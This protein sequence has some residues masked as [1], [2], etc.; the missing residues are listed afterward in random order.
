MI[1]Q[2]NFNW[3][4][5]TLGCHELDLP[6]VCELAQKH[7][8]HQLEIRGLGDSLNLPEYLE[9]KFPDGPNSVQQILDQHHQAVIALNS[10]FNLLGADEAG[11]TELLAFARWAEML[12]VP[13]VRIFGGG[14]MSQP[15]TDDDLAEAVANL[16]WWHQQRDQHQWKTQV[17]LETHTGFSSSDRCL[18]LQEASGKP[19]DIIWDTHHTW[20]QGKESA[21][22]T[23]SK[24]GPMIKHVHI[25]D[26]V[27]VPSARHPYSYVLPGE[28]EFPVDDVLSV[29]DKNNYQGIV[30]LEWERKW[31]PYMTDLDT[32]LQTLKTA[33]W[34]PT[35]NPSVTTE[36]TEGSVA[37]Q[38]Y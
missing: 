28:G 5:S 10:S 4:I 34:R 29:L 6:A 13:F 2:P 33:G 12:D 18:Q 9:A 17:A 27:S 37:N 1:V 30:S 32:A 8:I 19:L 25:K 11:R 21:Q 36:T 14:C 35:T 26:S 23:W 15:L 16:Q 24:M 3:G 22:A 38:S 20:K 7:G 31:H